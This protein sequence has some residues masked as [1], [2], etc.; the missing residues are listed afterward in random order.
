MIDKYLEPDS[1]LE[2]WGLSGEAVEF[3]KKSLN[4]T[5][6]YIGEKHVL[7]QQQNKEKMLRNIQLTNLLNENHVPAVKFVKTLSGEWTA[8]D[9]AYYLM[10]RIKGEHIDFFESPEAAYE[11]GRGLAQLHETLLKNESTLEYNDYDFVSEWENYTKPGL[12]G[13]SPVLVEETEM[14]IRK[15]SEKLPRCPIHRD[16]Y[17]GNVLFHDG[18]IS[19]WLDFELNRKD[20]RIYDLAYFLSGLIAGKIDNPQAIETWKIIKRNLLAGYGE[21]SPLSGEETEAIPFLMIVVNLLF[22]TYWNNIGKPEESI[23]AKKLAEWLFSTQHEMS[24]YMKF[25]TRD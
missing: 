4:S 2:H 25:N 7:R 1:I 23:N 21:A 18:K 6:W 22:V 19:G 14:R 13:V 5:T 17:S 15:L 20:V 8:P 11:L 3:V 10:E 16:V 9:G 24:T 12:V